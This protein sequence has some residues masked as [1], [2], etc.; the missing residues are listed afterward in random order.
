MTIFMNVIIMLYLNKMPMYIIIQFHIT[1]N[2]IFI[3]QHGRTDSYRV[4]TVPSL[5]DDNKTVDGKPKVWNN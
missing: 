1:N 2:I 5:F 4:A 3:L